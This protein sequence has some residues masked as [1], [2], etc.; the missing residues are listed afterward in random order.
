MNDP[1][2]NPDLTAYCKRDYRP[3]STLRRILW[4]AVSLVGF[5]SPFPW[6]MGGKAW[7]LRLFGARIGRGLVIKPRV[8]IKFPWKLAIGKHCW[9]GERVWIDNPAPVSLGDHVVISQGACLVTGN[10][11]YRSPH[12][13]L[14]LEPILVGDGAWLAAHCRVGPGANVGARAI[15]TF[16]S[17]ATDSLLPEMVY[18]GN[19]AVLRRA[20]GPNPE[21]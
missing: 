5:E 11:D 18:G 2:A 8:Q 14:R 16:G 3:G 10:H 7:V 19:P 13:D 20:R 4:Y 6:P 15:L 21:R 1:A 12:F 17:V 9:I